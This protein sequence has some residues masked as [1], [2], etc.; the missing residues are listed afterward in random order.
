MAPTL[1]PRYALHSETFPA[2]RQDDAF[3][4]TGRITEHQD[5][6]LRAGLTKQA[7]AERNLEE[8]WPGFDDQAVIEFGIERCLL[9]LTQARDGLPPGHTVWHLDQASR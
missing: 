6:A 5:P 2:P 8:P 9:T 3:Y 4:I 1:E 7:L